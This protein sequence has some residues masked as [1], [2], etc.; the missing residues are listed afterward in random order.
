MKT[1][2]GFDYET[3]R[4]GPENLAPKP[5]CLSAYINADP[6]ATHPDE[7]TY[8]PDEDLELATAADGDLEHLIRSLLGSASS[9]GVVLVSA[10][11]AYDLAVACN[12]H[13]DLYETAFDLLQSGKIADV[14]VR[15]KLLNLA[16]YGDLEYTPG[17]DGS[18][19]RV[20]YSLGA[21]TKDYLGVVVEGKTKTDKKGE[22]VEGA[23]AWRVNYD[24][25]EDLPLAEWPE[26]AA[27]YAIYDS[28]YPTLIYRA[29]QW[30]AEKVREKIGMDPLATEAFRCSVRFALYLMSAKGVCVDAEEHAKIVGEIQTALTPENLNLLVETG[31]LRPGQPP[32]PYKNGAKD[33]VDGCRGKARKACSCPVKIKAAVK[34]SVDVKALH[35]HVLDL[36]KEYPEKVEL[37]YTEKKSLQVDKAFLE[38]FAHLCPVL[39]QYQNRQKLQKLVTTDLPR[40]EWPKGSGVAAKVLHASFDFLKET[41]R[42]SSYASKAYPSWNCQNPHPRVR[43]AIVPREGYV[44][45][46]VDY[47]GMELG[48]LA[49]K[50][51]DLFGFSVLRDVINSGKDAHAYLGAHLAYYLSEEFHE[52]L[53]DELDGVEPTGEDLYA[54]FVACKK[55]D[56]EPVRKF[57]KH[58]RTFA[59]PTGLGYPGGLGPKTFVDYAHATYRIECSEELASDLREVW[60]KCFPEM[61]LYLEWISQSCE[62]PNN[63]GF[64]YSTPLGM[65]RAAASYCAAAN[66]AGLQSPSAEGALLAVCSVVRSTVADSSSVLYPDEHGPR[67]HALL[68]VHDEIIGEARIDVAHEVAHEVSNI[69]VECMTIITPNVTPKAEPVLMTI[70]D[71]GAEP[72]YEN[73]RLVPWKSEK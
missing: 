72:A 40:M 67:H 31:I 52:S 10:N 7:L 53:N 68:F 54:S 1:L 62:D 65:Y 39:T 43:A 37:R 13:P 70:W 2:I 34:E 5:V 38:D 58:Y 8:D 28:V 61:K 6:E 16:Q 4:F 9:E 64:A 47:S 17:P 55:H 18:K 15:E 36:K 59:K 49:Q 24:A 25:L 19:R 66:G 29:Q 73:G 45:Y 3:H 30:R 26:E 12:Q 21:L 60:L 46:S 27:A 44:F 48:T 32:Q 56:S 20:D 57:Y 63:D 22:I 42:T 35:K 23:D 41:G 69:M 71:K 51:Y 14:Q 33:H 50:C 11:V